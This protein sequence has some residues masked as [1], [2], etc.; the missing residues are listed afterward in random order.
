MSLGSGRESDVAL[1]RSVNVGNAFAYSETKKIPA[2][3]SDGFNVTA[4]SIERARVDN[5][6]IS[7]RNVQESQP[8][9]WSKARNW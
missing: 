1:W 9:I 5:E 7:G 3:H 4:D 2:N 8:K 6:H